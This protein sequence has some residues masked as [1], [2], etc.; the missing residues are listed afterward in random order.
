MT[1]TRAPKSLSHDERKA[2]EAAFA[3]RPFN[4]AWSTSAR[5]IYDG[6]SKALPRTDVEVSTPSKVEEFAETPSAETHSLQPQK[7]PAREHVGE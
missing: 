5:V 4:E 6:I 2:A 1:I 3:G 7:S